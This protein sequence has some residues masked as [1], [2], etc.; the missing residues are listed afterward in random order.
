MVIYD[1]LGTNSYKFTGKERDTETQNDYFGARFHQSN[2]GRFMSPDPKAASG[3]RINPQTWNRYTYTLNNPLKFFD[4]DGMDVV[5]AAGL[6]DNDREYVVKHLARLY[7]NPAGR[8][9]L[10]RA[11]ESKFT[12]SVGQGHLGRTELTNAAPGTTVVFGGKVRL[13][14][15]LTKATTSEDGR[16]LVAQSPSSPG[17]P[18]IQVTIDKEQSGLMGKDPAKVFGH[19]FGGHL[20]DLL[21]AAESND[22][23][24]IDSIAPGEKSSEAAEKGLGKLPNEPSEKD[25][26]GV[27]ELLKPKYYYNR[28]YF[29]FREE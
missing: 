5:L 1:Y 23:Q 24:F 16:Q 13:E 22:A 25:V 10:Q 26:E 4:P 27:K 18:P 21:N 11:D 9:Y 8:A 12:V 19:E 29:P 7:A 28:G 2:L 6:S 20:A 3:N 15:G 17:A 14:G